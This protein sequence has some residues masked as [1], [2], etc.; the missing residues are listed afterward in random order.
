[1]LAIC[2]THQ[3]GVATHDGDCSRSDIVGRKRF[4]SIIFKEPF[5]EAFVDV[6]EWDG[7][8]VGVVVCW[9]L[10]RKGGGPLGRDGF[11]VGCWWCG[12][13]FVVFLG[14]W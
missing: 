6:G 9:D 8:S 13:V 2:R 7:G 12:G 3:R 1:M 14:G 11:V 10:G 5:S 4:G